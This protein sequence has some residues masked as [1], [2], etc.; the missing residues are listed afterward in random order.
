MREVGALVCAQSRILRSVV[1][2]GAEDMVVDESVAAAFAV[3]RSEADEQGIDHGVLVKDVED[4]GACTH[5]VGDGIEAE[6]EIR[7]SAGEYI[8]RFLLVVRIADKCLAHAADKPGDIAWRAGR[9][10]G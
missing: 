9:L 1:L 3:M 2:L 8:R 6:L 10:A 4:F 5:L 7:R